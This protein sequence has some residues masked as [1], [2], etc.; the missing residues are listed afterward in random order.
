V[1]PVRIPSQEEVLQV[2]RK[3]GFS[4]LTPFQEKLIPAIL[5]GKDIAAEPAPGSG[6]TLGF[7]LPLILGLRG[8]GLAPRAV[9]LAPTSEEV[10][11]IAREYA[12]IARFVRDAPVCVPL[13]EIEDA[14]REQRRLEKGATIVAGT[15][16]RVIDHIRR[17]SLGFDQL[18]TTIVEEPEGDARADF[19]K[20]V[21]FI[22]A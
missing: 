3:A 14:R 9:I 10:G 7:I 8:A 15:V 12:R 11:K 2:F 18:Q 22:F 16:E 5:K 20:D 13:G 19:I 4:T 17:G 21:Q 1:H 6:K